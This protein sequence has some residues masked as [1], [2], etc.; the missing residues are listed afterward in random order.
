LLTGAYERYRENLA[1]DPE[2]AE[3]LRRA[4]AARCILGED[5]SFI[6]FLR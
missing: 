4:E 1:A 5:R 2:A 6:R 3:N